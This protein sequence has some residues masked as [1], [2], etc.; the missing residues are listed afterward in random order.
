MYQRVPTLSHLL[1][2][3][4]YSQSDFPR[5]GTTL[6]IIRDINTLIDLDYPRILFASSGKT[7]QQKWQAGRRWTILGTLVAGLNKIAVLNTLAIAV[8]TGCASR[9]RMDSGLGSALVPGLGGAEWDAGIWNKVVVFRDFGC[10]FVGVQKCQSRSLISREEIGEPGK[11]VGFE[12]THDGVVKQQGPAGGSVLEE[13]RRRVSRSPAKLRKRAFDE[14]A[15]SEG[16]EADEYGWAETDEDAFTADAAG[17][18]APEQPLAATAS[19]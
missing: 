16:E 8:T 5:S 3:V 11:V 7:P 10:R 17:E 12:I 19:V 6:M 2:L 18:E 15:D 9:T 13:A 14:V 4:L 1:A